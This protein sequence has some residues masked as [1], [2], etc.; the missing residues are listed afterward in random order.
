MMPCH[1]G[2]SSAGHCRWR[3]LLHASSHLPLSCWN[4]LHNDP[5]I[6]VSARVP[7]VPLLGPGM[8]FAERSLLRFCGKRSRR[9]RIS[10]S[11]TFG[12]KNATR[13]RSFPWAAGSSQEWPESSTWERTSRATAEKLL[14]GWEQSRAVRGEAR[15]RPCAPLLRVSGCPGV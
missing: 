13:V 15:Q 10:F 6:L 11:T 2:I 7:Q 3:A 12:F 4:S 9:T 14:C 8:T 1:Y 5:V